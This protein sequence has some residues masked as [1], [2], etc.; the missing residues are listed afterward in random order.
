MFQLCKSLGIKRRIQQKEGHQMN[1]TGFFNNISVQGLED[2]SE[3]ITIII[4]VFGVV[5][6]AL[7]VLETMWTMAM[8]SPIEVALMTKREQYKYKIN[9]RGNSY[10]YPLSYKPSFSIH[11]TEIKWRTR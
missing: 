3:L 5:M 4:A 9:K 8:S 2:I 6:A 11:A 7:K 10:I 1:V